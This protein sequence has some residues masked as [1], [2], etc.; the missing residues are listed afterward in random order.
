MPDLNLWYPYCVMCLKI[1]NGFW[2]N[3][4]CVNGKIGLHFY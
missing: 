1:A 2:V 4:F 3:D